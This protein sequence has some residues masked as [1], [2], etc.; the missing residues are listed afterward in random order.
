MTTPEQQ[1]IYDLILRAW[2]NENN[3]YGR[4]KS[5]TKK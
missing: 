3:L 4:R 5:C 2:T 1:I